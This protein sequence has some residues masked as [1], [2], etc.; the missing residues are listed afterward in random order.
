MRQRAESKI[1]DGCEECS[2]S[3]IVGECIRLPVRRSARIGSD[4][5]TGVLGDEYEAG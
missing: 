5:G 1:G 2:R 4:C 3:R